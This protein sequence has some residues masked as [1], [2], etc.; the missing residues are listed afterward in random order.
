MNDFLPENIGE[1]IVAS[2]DAIELGAD[3][4]EFTIDQWLDDGLL[5]NIPWVGWVFR[6]KSAYSSISDRILL[7]KIVKFL[8][9]LHSNPNH[10]R[11]VLLK[12]LEK[13]PDKRRRIGEQILIALENLDDLEKPEL[14]AK[15][16]TYYLD[17]LL[18]YREFS[19]LVDAIT[20]CHGTDLAW[21]YTPFPRVN[22][23]PPYE[24]LFTAG[25][26]R[27]KSRQRVPPHRENQAL[28]EMSLEFE[29]SRLGEL[30]QAIIS[31]RL[32]NRPDAES[33][34]K[35]NLGD[36]NTKQSEQ[37]TDFV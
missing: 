23:R 3:I 18:S 22:M 20:K 25:L 32:S 17:G 36:L 13:S 34:R 27:L 30:L 16:F 11:S 5:K 6:A 19:Q 28:P 26:S 24:R 35:K 31:D 4:A 10:R 37:G 9:S 15:C 1:S 33:R 14:I 2:G 12:Q 7:A 29:M 21:F 8:I